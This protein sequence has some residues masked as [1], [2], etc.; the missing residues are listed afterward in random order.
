MDR[1][2]FLITVF[3]LIADWLKEQPVRQRGPQPILFDSEV[4]TIEVVGAFLGVD[5]DEGVDAY[6]RR[7]YPDLFPRLARVHRTTFARQAANL[8]KVKEALWQELLTHIAYDPAVSMIDSFPLPVC[9]FARSPRCQRLREYATYGYDDVNQQIY[10]GLRVHLRL[11]WPGVIV[12]VALAPANE[13]DLPVATEALLPDVAGWVLAD[14]NYQSAWQ[15]HPWVTP[16]VYPLI[17]PKHR[18][19]ESV[20]WPRELTQMRRRIETVFSQL[21][22]RYRTKRVWARDLWHLS[23]RWLR[24]VGSHTMAVLLCQHAGLPPLQFD[25]LLTD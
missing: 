24:C 20:P 3:C 16:D 18:K 11:C 19:R 1:I 23:A 7:F 15:P 22:E 25:R 13:A 2:T 17:P 5:T 21:V 10:Y 9:R 8:W 12:A 14:R 4:L 6:F